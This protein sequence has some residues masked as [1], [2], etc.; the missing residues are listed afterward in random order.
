MRRLTLAMAVGLVALLALSGTAVGTPVEADFE[1]ELTGA[2][3]VPPVA[4]ATTGEARFD[5]NEAETAIRYELEVQQATD[6]LG[7]AG[8]HIH[9]A[10]A[11]QNGP[12]VVF[13]AGALPGGL[14]GQVEIK[15]TLTQANIVNDSCGATIAEL[16]DSMEAGNT[17]VNAHSPAHPGGE[18]RGQI[19]E[20]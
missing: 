17:Y 11:G 9:C 3:E 6:I 19:E 20:V 8:A 13:L 15:A 10:P 7:A 5:V 12:V 2:E 18:V 16:V 1:A 4:T 14:D